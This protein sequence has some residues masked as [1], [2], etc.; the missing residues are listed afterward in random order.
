MFQGTTKTD[1]NCHS[2]ICPYQ[3]Y[4]RCYWPDFG[5]KTHV[6]KFYKLRHSAMQPAYLLHFFL[7]IILWLLW[8]QSICSCTGKNPDCYWPTH[9][10]TVAIIIQ[11]VQKKMCRS[12]CLI[13][14]A[15][16]MLEGWD[17]IHW[18]GGKH[19][20]IWYSILL[21]LYLGSRISYRNVFVLQTKPR[22]SSFQ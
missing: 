10:P 14:L 19:F 6:T 3:E 15:T 4:F 12:F 21:Y 20:E 8:T 13:S 22:I 2:D 7:S 9:I 18:K 11:G 17:I 1:S 5:I 16:N